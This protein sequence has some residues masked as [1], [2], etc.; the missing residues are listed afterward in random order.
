MHEQIK[1]IWAGSAILTSGLALLAGCASSGDANN[2]TPRVELPAGTEDD[3]AA[4][5]MPVGEYDRQLSLIE[6][7]LNAPGDLSIELAPADP[8]AADADW[9]DPLLDRDTAVSQQTPAASEPKTNAM[10]NAIADVSGDEQPQTEG[11]GLAI[12]AG[13][14]PATEPT[15]QERLAKEAARLAPLVREF[16]EAQASPV[17]A[18][19]YL[20]ALEALAPG[21][22]ETQYGPLASAAA[23]MQ[24]TD[25]EIA[26][27]EAAKQAASELRQ[28][29]AT[30]F[31]DPETVAAAIQT[32]SE[33]LR[34]VRTLTLNDVKLC[35]RVENYGVYRAVQQ[36]GDR[37]KFVAGREHPVIVYSELDHFTHTP[38]AENG[39]PGF[40]VNVRQALRIYRIGTEDAMDT[41]N[42][43]V[44]Q[45]EPQ[46]VLDFSRNRLRDF[47]IVQVI[48][49]PRT[50]SVG[51]Y[52]LKVIATDVVSGEE[53]EHGIVFDVVA[54]A[55][56]LEGGDAPERSRRSGYYDPDR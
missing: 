40:T 9:T 52:R 37:Y 38:G 2:D 49:L 46:T 19:V 50:L 56:A 53:V 3:A 10:A 24:L 23:S 12:G 45:L 41:E 55:S 11:D 29:L 51:S 1:W 28:E 26:L 30:D 15:A 36:H 34:S 27:I 22:L 31:V 54:H 5:A 4:G 14:G 43:L 6:Q 16:G 8:V 17:G 47:F 35:L 7:S 39:V 21:L 25:D 44:W 32:L 33:E 20:A 13:A 18:M 42:T 48:E